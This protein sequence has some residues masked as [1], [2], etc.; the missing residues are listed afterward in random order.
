MVERAHQPAT[1]R[2]TPPSCPARV[3]ATRTGASRAASPTIFGA[4]QGRNGAAVARENRASPD[5]RRDLDLI[6]STPQ[7]PSRTAARSSPRAVTSPQ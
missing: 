3:I 5:G 1:L 4:G 2:R 7:Q 6:R